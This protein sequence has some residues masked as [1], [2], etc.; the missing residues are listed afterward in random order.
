MLNW[1]QSSC[2]V[3]SIAN[4]A[5][6]CLPAYVVSGGR[7]PPYAFLAIIVAA[8]CEGV[9]LSPQRI[10]RNGGEKRHVMLWNMTH[11]VAVLICLQT[12]TVVANTSPLHSGQSELLGAALLALGLALRTAAIRT[13]GVHFADGFEPSAATRVIA[14]PYRFIPHPAEF[15]LLLV[16]SG[17]GTLICGWS[18]LTAMLYAGLTVVSAV[19]V[20]MEEMALHGLTDNEPG[21]QLGRLFFGDRVR[22]HDSPNPFRIV[23]IVVASEPFKA[24]TGNA[25]Q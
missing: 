20:C 21:A 7:V 10:A 17:F 5:L 14:G 19:R 23:D 18:I 12:L 11:G 22:Q 15:G 13:L 8:L 4:A 2:L 25:Y 1:R 6:V 3:A 16:I 9:A 24:Y